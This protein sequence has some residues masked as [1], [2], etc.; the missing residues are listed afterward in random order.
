[1]G[2]LSWLMAALAALLLSRFLPA[3]RQEGRRF[4]SLAETGAA[5][6][7][8]L[9]AGLVATASDFG[10]LDEI[11]LPAILLAFFT[12]AAAIGAIR[13]LRVLQRGP[14]RMNE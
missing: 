14:R 2:I 6:V 12:G 5:G 8:A 1:M 4:P 10:G 11:A 9:C 7:V 13:L 3:G